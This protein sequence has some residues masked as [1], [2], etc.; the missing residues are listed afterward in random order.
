MK[1]HFR[2][3]RNM[4]FGQLKNGDV[5]RR[6]DINPD[7]FFIKT[8]RLVLDEKNGTKIGYPIV[9]ALNISDNYFIGMM[10]FFEDDTPVE[11]MQNPQLVVD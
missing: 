4:V 7:E 3:N 2:N 5:F 6:R 10:F 11:K 9:N 8:E 1:T